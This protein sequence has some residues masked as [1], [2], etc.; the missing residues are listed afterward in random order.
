MLRTFNLLFIFI[1]AITSF[2]AQI[3]N[4]IPQNGLNAY[5]SFQENLT[6]YNDISPNNH[7]TA[8]NGTL[9]FTSD[10]FASAGQALQGGAGSLSISENSFAYGYL[11][12]FSIS[13]WFT[14]S[15]NLGGRLFSTETTTSNY[16][17]SQ[18]SNTEVGFHF[19]SQSN[20]LLGNVFDVNWHHAVYVYEGS[21]AMLYLDGIIV[22]VTIMDTTQVLSYG[23]QHQIGSNASSIIGLD[24]WDGKFDD[25]AIWN[26][27]LTFCEIQSIYQS[28]FQYSLISAGPDLQICEGYET[29]LQAQNAVSATWSDG[30]LNG[31]P[32]IPTLSSYVLAGTDVNGCI[33]TDTLLINLIQAV[34]VNQ[35]V[36]SCTPYLF[37]GQ[38]LT[39][40]G[41]YTS[42]FN[43][44]LGCDSIVTVQFQLLQPPNLSATNIFG[45]FLQTTQAPNYA[46]QWYNCDTQ[47]PI[48]GANDYLFQ[49]LDS[50]W[51][52]VVAINSCGTDTSE[53]VSLY[54]DASTIENQQVAISVYPNPVSTTLFV[55]GLSKDQ[56][57]A[58]QIFNELGQLCLA[59]HF[60]QD[61]IG[62]ASLPDGLYLL[63]I[64]QRVFRV[65]KAN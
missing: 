1:F 25:L 10:R 40:N 7:T 49:V 51:Y 36:T 28:Q 60:N 55:S 57:D 11:D 12:T 58:F 2:V 38:L 19:G 45:N 54:P 42:T 50:A 30:V 23:A 29:S 62:I 27:A 17:I 61:S 53:C 4:F 43:S 52:Q 15:M 46:Y 59:G 44:I 8:V 35:N 3:P 63:Q 47:E 26:R 18:Q 16:F 64:D 32:F 6:N 9:S 14:K 48:L 41:T 39:N 65:V 34:Y 20:V 22:D 31:V 33:G 24:Y 56:S 37:N 21:M 5:L 13:V